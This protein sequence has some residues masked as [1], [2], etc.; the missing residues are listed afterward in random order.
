MSAHL[1]AQIRR[2]AQTMQEAVADLYRWQDDIAKKD[3]SLKDKPAVAKKLPPIRG[4][5][6]SGVSF[7]DKSAAPARTSGGKSRRKRVR[8]N[9]PSK[10][11]AG[12]GAGA[13]RSSGGESKT[14]DKGE[15]GRISAYDYSAWDRFDVDAAIQ[16][17]SSSA[18]YTYEDEDD[19][20]VEASSSQASPE[21]VKAEGNKAFAAGKYANAVE[22]YS[23]AMDLD[24]TN[25]VYPANRA[26]AH[27]KMKDYKA[28]IRDCSRSI[29]LDPTYFKS[30][31]R[32]ASAYEALDKL[33]EAK[34]DY[35]RLVQLKPTTKAYARSLGD[36][37]R[38]LKNAAVERAA[39]ESGNT[40]TAPAQPKATTAAGSG[41]AKKPGKKKMVIEEVAEEPAAVADEPLE[42]TIMIP[43]KVVGELPA[44]EPFDAPAPATAAPPAA[45]TS[46]AAAAPP[47]TAAPPAATILP[48]ASTPATIDD[49]PTVTPP[50][51]LYEF[52]REWATLAATDPTALPLLLHIAP[53]SYKTFFN[54]QMTEPI[55]V[56][57]VDVLA[58]AVASDVGHPLAD[59]ALDY[60]ARMLSALPSVPRFGM[61][62]MFLPSATNTTIRSLVTQ[63]KSSPTAAAALAP[64]AFTP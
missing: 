45:S 1:Q 57:I 37:V 25:A 60:A 28:T 30:Y 2:N 35:E 51:S 22:L 63:I 44:Y 24:P 6:A 59:A 61:L 49:V 20:P 50:A 26:M 15:A 41:A 39:A 12:S 23:Q 55:L 9:K 21:E 47:T 5:A 14:K 11:A 46:A 34:A 3:K 38:R 36:V 56:K 48:V 8:R 58:H 62:S 4:T 42:E 43:V 40:P 54:T 33:V 64:S 27:L 17:I 31:A 13:G 29:A 10:T 52:Q 18:E 7:S 53:E 32:R 16:E 19:G